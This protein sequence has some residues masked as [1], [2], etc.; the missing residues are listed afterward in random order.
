MRCMNRITLLFVV[1][2]NACT[3][4]SGRELR[5]GMPVRTA[6][7]FV[8][9]G[10]TP[11]GAG[12]PG[13]MPGMDAPPAAPRGKDKRVLPPTREPGLWAADG[14]GASASEAL[15][16]AE[17]PII[18][19]PSPEDPNP[20]TDKGCVELVNEHLHNFNLWDRLIETRADYR[21][22]IA[23]QLYARCIDANEVS[24]KAMDEYHNKLM[25]QKRMPY[26]E[27]D[28]GER[29]KLAELAAR[30]L[31]DLACPSALEL[32]TNDFETQVGSA[33]LRGAR[34]VQ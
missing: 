18:L 34:S 29:Q 5:D 3:T 1:A 21:A 17:V 22:C 9:P 4:S 13:Y 10:Y 15:K 25:R 23:V 8:R 16:I 24:A 12:L 27:H 28:K 2:L 19:P 30:R 11:A 14:A 33:L 31:V 20:Q 26:V 6:P 32:G 7:A